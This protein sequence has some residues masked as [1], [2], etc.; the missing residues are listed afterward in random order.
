MTLQKS[1]RVHQ[2]HQIIKQS[3]LALIRMRNLNAVPDY[4]NLTTLFRMYAIY[5]NQRLLSMYPAQTC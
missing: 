1:K 4:G 5:N 2:S 3:F